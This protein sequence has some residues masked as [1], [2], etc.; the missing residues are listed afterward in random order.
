MNRK[1]LTVLMLA[2]GLALGFSPPAS[3]Q[4]GCT[5]TCEKC[6]IDYKAGTATCTNCTISGCQPT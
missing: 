4:S 3:S 2:G 5:I 1:L 6:D